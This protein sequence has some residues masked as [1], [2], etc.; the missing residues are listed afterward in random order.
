LKTVFFYY[1]PVQKDIYWADEATVFFDDQ[2]WWILEK[3]T[4]NLV[5]PDELV[6][7]VHGYAKADTAAL[8]KPL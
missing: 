8:A 6:G 3:G 2:G 4:R 1:N 7:S 5:L